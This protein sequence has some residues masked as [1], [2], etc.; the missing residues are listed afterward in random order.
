MESKMIS[1]SY[2]LVTLCRGDYKTYFTEFDTYGEAFESYTAHKVAG[3]VA[4]IHEIDF[5]GPLAAKLRWNPNY[6]S[7]CTL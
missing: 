5:Q 7:A 3:D 1:C 4:A 2:F 6:K